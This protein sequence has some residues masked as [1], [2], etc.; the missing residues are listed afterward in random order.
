[1]ATLILQILLIPLGLTDSTSTLIRGGT[2]VEWSPPFDHVVNSYLP[3]LRRMGFEA[4]AELKRWGW[5]PVGQGEIVCTVLARSGVTAP[6]PIELRERGALKRIGGRSR[7]QP[8]RSYS[9]TH[10]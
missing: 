3:M 2:H 5:Y 7:Y 10:G 1:V 4:N 8:A 9:P 6:R